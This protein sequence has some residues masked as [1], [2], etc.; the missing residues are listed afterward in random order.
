MDFDGSM[1]CS[2]VPNFER[3]APF[4]PCLKIDNGQISVL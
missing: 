4:L 3:R 1:R 2:F